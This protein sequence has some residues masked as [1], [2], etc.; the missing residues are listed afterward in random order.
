MLFAANGDFERKE[1][2]ENQ[3]DY[4]NALFAKYGFANSV[5][6]KSCVDFQ[7]NPIPWYSYPSIEYL[8]QLDFSDKT[9]FE[10]GCGNSSLWWAMRAKQVVSVEDNPQWYQSRLQY[11]MPNLSVNLCENQNDYCNAIFNY[12]CLF[13][14]IVVDGKF[15]D[16]CATNAIKKLSSDG[17]II[18][19]NSD[20]VQEFDEYANA[21]KIFSEADFLQVDFHG[22]GPINPWTWTTTV[23]FSRNFRFKP[24]AKLQ[25]SKPICALTEA[26]AALAENTKYKLRKSFEEILQR[27][28]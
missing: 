17:M 2:M 23:Y 25:P 5:K 21:S 15:R 10:F 3:L 8:S 28:R 14:V 24:I 26:N 11:Q 22:A 4:P 18:F 9:I 27:N 20:R 1:K 6:T 16:N 12:S 13:D 19:D 7:G